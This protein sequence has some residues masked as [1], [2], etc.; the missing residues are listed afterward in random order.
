MNTLLSLATAIQIAWLRELFLDDIQSEVRVAFDATAKRVQAAE[1]LRF[2]DLALSAKR[3]E[4]PPADEAARL[5]AEEVV[6]GRLV[7]KEWDHAVEQWILRLNLLSKWC[8]ELQ[9]P[10]ITDDDRRHLIEQICHGAFGYKEIKAKPVKPV[11]KSWL[12]PKQQE[13]LE[14]HAP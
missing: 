4:P 10:P 12:S 9:L 5:L 11:I 3:V 14:K 13:I 2:R 6:A 7:L 1:L 8:P